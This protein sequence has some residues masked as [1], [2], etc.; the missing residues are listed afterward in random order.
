LRV[1]DLHGAVVGPF[2]LPFRRVRRCNQFAAGRI[3]QR[4]CAQRLSDRGVEHQ[5]DARSVA[6]VH[7]VT[8]PVATGFLA[9]CFLAG[10]CRID[11]TFP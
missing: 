11:R 4:R 1:V 7:V 9:L 6:L 8:L 2:S 5:L 3:D 10:E